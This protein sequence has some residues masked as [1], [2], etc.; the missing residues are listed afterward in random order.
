MGTGQVFVGGSSLL[1]DIDVGIA[2]VSAAFPTT[3]F[4]IAIVLHNDNNNITTCQVQ[5]LGWLS[6]G[7][8]SQCSNRSILK[9]VTMWTCKGVRRFMCRFFILVDV[10]VR[11]QFMCQRS[12]RWTG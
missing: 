10:P 5:Q 2:I 9:V 11:K 4:A 1:R 3:D 12:L 6:T 7:E 8:V